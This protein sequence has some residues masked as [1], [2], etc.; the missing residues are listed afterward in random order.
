MAN[1]KQCSDGRKSLRHSLREILKCRR[2]SPITDEPLTSGAGVVRKAFPTAPYLPKFSQVSLFPDL[3]S[4]R[5]DINHYNISISDTFSL[6][7]SL[8]S[9]LT[10]SA[11]CFFLR[12][13]TRMSNIN[14]VDLFTD[15]P[16]LLHRQPRY[17]SVPLLLS[18]G[19]SQNAS[20]TSPESEISFISRESTLKVR[21]S[22]RDWLIESQKNLTDVAPRNSTLSLRRSNGS[23]DLRGSVRSIPDTIRE[24]T[25][26]AES[27]ENDVQSSKNSSTINS[28][29]NASI[30]LVK[31]F[32][33]F[34]VLDTSAPSCPIIA[35]S[36]DLRHHLQIGETL[37]LDVQECTTTSMDIVINSNP[38]EGEVTYLVLYIPLMSPGSGTSRF[39]LA[40]LVDVTAFVHEASQLPHL[41][42][43]E[44]DEEVS[45]ADEI[46]SPFSPVMQPNCVTGRYELLAEDL[47]CGCFLA[48]EPRVKSSIEVQKQ[49]EHDSEDIWLALVEEEQRRP[50]KQSSMNGVTDCRLSPGKARHS[51]S[52]STEATNRATTA[53]SGSIDK[54]L[55]DFMSSL[56]QLYVESFL[57][58]RSPIDGKYYEICNVSPVVYARGEYATGHLTHTPWET[59][60]SLSEQLGAE[61]PF[62]TMVCWGSRGDEKQ[63]YCVPLYGQGSI[64]WICFLVEICV[65]ILW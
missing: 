31:H 41:E 9:A 60:E 40:A 46:S 64:T 45:A 57:L 23:R 12:T 32:G 42:S 11:S 44:E 47:L 7:P 53:A 55:E 27:Q 24:T 63:L 3:Q 15:H 29:S 59:V 14:R 16:V 25:A 43:I 52:T 17:E 6:S 36:E 54:V 39:L 58:A 4:S 28:R 30:H 51:L 26:Q 20:L 2:R 13:A 34:C 35:T 62:R 48:D 21:T 22:G 18:E 8:E 37:S 10:A 61:K 1:T 50:D 65:P 19:V 56:Q 38:D 5:F 33:S 49:S